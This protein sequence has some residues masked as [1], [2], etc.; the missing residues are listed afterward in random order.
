METNRQASDR[1]QRYGSYA[2]TMRRQVIYQIMFMLEEE[3]TV[4][5][6]TAS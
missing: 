3:D 5:G 1:G 2:N 4:G 6:L